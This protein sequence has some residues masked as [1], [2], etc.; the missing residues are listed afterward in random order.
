MAVEMIQMY[1][2][3]NGTV[4]ARNRI[5][6]IS[7][8]AC[9]NG[10]VEQIAAQ[11]PIADPYTHPYGCD[12]LGEDLTLSFRCLER[13]GTHPNVGAVLVVGL[14]CEEIQA[15]ELRRAIAKEQ[16]NC[17]SIVVQEVGGT[18][19]SVERGV[20]IVNRYAKQLAE[21]ERSSVPLSMLTVGLECGGS[22]F[23]SGIAANP[24][25]GKMAERLVDAGCKVVFGETA[26]L[27]GA[28]PILKNLCVDPAH[29]EWICQR[30]KRVEQ[31]AM[32]MKV[33]LRGTQPSPG[34]INGG[35]TTI[36]EKSLGGVCKIGSA[37]IVDV[38]NFA[39]R[40]KT[41]GISF[42]DTPGNDLACSLGIAA[43]GAQVILFTTGRGTP[44][45]FAAA[46]VIK[47]TGNRV[48]AERMWEN[49]DADLS[50]I[51]SRQMSVRQGGELL[52]DML[53]RTAQGWETAAERLGH[54]E[55][56]LYRISPILT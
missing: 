26:E 6:V 38:L 54:R 56:S 20:E 17:E 2:R 29:Y 39:D 45:G 11:C 31:V 22:D 7:T 13:M 10:V 53:L 47:L 27:M 18:P 19:R 21:M 41:P 44:M 48:V 33:D 32:D 8:V 34:N 51:V 15:D 3:E 1:R 36:E 46:P 52:Y 23:T 42:M 49:I 40:A 24:A 43:S 4:G 14:G 55:F 25:M 30:I 50:G 9:V 28:E 12:Q 37:K 5:A 16:P 35:L